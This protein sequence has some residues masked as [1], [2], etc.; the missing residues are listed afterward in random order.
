MQP[1][2]LRRLARF[3]RMNILALFDPSEVNPGRVR[4]AERKVLE[5]GPGVRMELFHARR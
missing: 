3:Y 2:P 1:Y 4:P 5:A